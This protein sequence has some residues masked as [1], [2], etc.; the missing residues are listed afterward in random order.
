MHNAIPGRHNS[1]QSNTDFVTVNGTVVDD[2][3]EDNEEK[4]KQ[5]IHEAIDL[6]E[7]RLSRID[8]AERRFSAIDLAARRRSSLIDADERR[9]SSL[10]DANERRPSFLFPIKSD[11]S[12]SSVDIPQRNETIDMGKKKFCYLKKK[13]T[14]L[15]MLRTER[16][17][18]V[19]KQNWLFQP[20][21]H[22]HFAVLP[23][24]TF[25]IP[26]EIYICHYVKRL[27]LTS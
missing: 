13:E 6:A 23:C 4:Q 24:A 11:W 2:H 8:S 16:E 27:K 25:G 17:M 18:R 26:I 10:I 14:D 15:Q 20:H 3:D 1:I 9:R 19:W 22:P 5:I 7:R 21:P 12:N